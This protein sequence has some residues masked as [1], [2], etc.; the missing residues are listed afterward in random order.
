M[1]VNYFAVGLLPIHVGCFTF[2][3]NRLIILIFLF[4]DLMHFLFPKL[5]CFTRSFSFINVSN[6]YSITD[7]KGSNLASWSLFSYLYLSSRLVL[8]AAIPKASFI[9]FFHFSIYVDVVFCSSVLFSIKI[10]IDSLG[11]HLSIIRNRLN[12]MTECLVQLC[13]YISLLSWY[14][15]LCLFPCISVCSFLIKFEFIRSTNPLVIGWYGM[16]CS[17]DIPKLVKQLIFEF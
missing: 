12:P 2:A 5:S 13:T 9:L 4:K 10:S 8:A 1:A 7:F 11:S 6:Q 3:L 17:R 15:E 16:V 14:F